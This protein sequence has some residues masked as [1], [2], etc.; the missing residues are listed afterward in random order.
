MELKNDRESTR[1]DR[2]VFGRSDD[3]R[4]RA[5]GLRETRGEPSYLHR[6]PSRNVEATSERVAAG[7]HLA[8]TLC[9]GCHLDPTTK[10]LTGNRLTDLPAQ[11]RVVLSANITRARRRG[12]PAGGRSDASAELQGSLAFRR[13][14]DEPRLPERKW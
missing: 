14:A 11:F 8:M 12:R 9:T 3:F 5:I 13:D 1:V 6:A 10:R 2:S 7:R 4:W